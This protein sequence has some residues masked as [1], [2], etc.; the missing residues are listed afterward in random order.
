ML[1]KLADLLAQPPA[2]LC[3]M[4]CLPGARRLSKAIRVPTHNVSAIDMVL[5]LTQL[6]HRGTAAL[7]QP[8]MATP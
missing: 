3:P 7:P 4:I 2:T 5:D 8:G 1:G 6:D